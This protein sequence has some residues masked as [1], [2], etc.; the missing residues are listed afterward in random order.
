M[1]MARERHCEAA[2]SERAHAPIGR[3]VSTHP[4]EGLEPQAAS[5]G[6]YATSSSPTRGGAHRTGS[7]CRSNAPICASVPCATGTLSAD[8]SRAAGSQCSRFHSWA[9]DHQAVWRPRSV[10]RFARPGTSV[11]QRVIASIASPVSDWH[12][13]PSESTWLLFLKHPH[14]LSPFALFT[15]HSCVFAS[16]LEANA[17]IRSVFALWSMVSSSTISLR[18]SSEKVPAS[19][20]PGK[21]LPCQSDGLQFHMIA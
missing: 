21:R 18:L 17:S 16:A 10:C 8:V 1:P 3:R 2:P 14:F 19:A 11:T 6:M 9:G 20:D 13:S 12:T 5:A 7:F 15:L 4:L